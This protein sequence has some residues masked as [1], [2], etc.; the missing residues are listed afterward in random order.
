MPNWCKNLLKAPGESLKDVLNE[1]NEVS[2]E[3][4]SPMPKELEKEVWFR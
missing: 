4:I 3:L 2:F 1:K